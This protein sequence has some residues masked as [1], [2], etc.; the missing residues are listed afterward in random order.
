MFLMFMPAVAG[1]CIL[2]SLAVGES[3]TKLD[4]HS[5]P[6]SGSKSCHEDRK[7]GIFLCPC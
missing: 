7:S 5:G 1:G 2:G 4:F 6:N 3:N